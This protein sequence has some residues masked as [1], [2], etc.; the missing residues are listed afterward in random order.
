MT[1]NFGNVY[2]WE[3]L[4]YILQ[5]CIAYSTNLVPK[6]LPFAVWTGFACRKFIESGLNVAMLPIRQMSAAQPQP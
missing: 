3:K 1:L 4:L 5:G 6:S 2:I